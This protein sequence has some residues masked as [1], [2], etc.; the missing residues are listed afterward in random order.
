MDQAS[1]LRVLSSSP[2]EPS[3]EPE[4]VTHIFTISSGKGGVGKSNFVLNVAIALRHHR[5]K[6]LVMDADMGLGNIDVLLGQIAR[7]NLSHVFANEKGLRDILM[8]GPSDI[9]FLPAASG[10]EWITNLNT[11]QKIEFLQKM[12]ALN[13]LY[14]I[15]LIDTGAGISSN[16]LYFNLAAQ[17]RIIVVTP[18]PTALTD[19][20]AL[21][22]VLNR[23]HQQKEFEVVVNAV[24]SEKEGLEV[25]RN[26]T[27]VADRFLDVRLGFL[28]SVRLDSHLGRAV[29]QQRPVVDFY[30]SAPISEDY[31][32]L[33]RRVSRMQAEALGGN[34]GLFWRRM[35]E[36]PAI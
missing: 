9:H 19:A 12:D 33:A 1:T 29:M 5:K 11:Q 14:D 7:F 26:L 25:Y 10:V 27:S 23:D 32:A 31:R 34:L 16:V 6:V 35:V 28:G 13:G 3:K 22:K 17:T 36:M 30:P 15:L 20:Y 21:I 4:R 8:Q 24:G 2:A 18:E